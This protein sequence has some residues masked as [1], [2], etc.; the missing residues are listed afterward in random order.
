LFWLRREDGQPPPAPVDTD[1]TQSDEDQSLR[2]VDQ[3]ALMGAVLAAVLAI[4]LPK[5]R[6]DRSGIGVGVAL[7]AI[8]AGYYR[9][10]PK[11]PKE[12]FDAWTRA[13]ALAGVT[14]L[15]L[16][17]ALAYPAQQKSIHKYEYQCEQENLKKYPYLKA[18]RLDELIDNCVGDKAGRRL[19]P[20]W[21]ALAI[22]IFF[23]HLLKWHPKRRPHRRRRRFIAARPRI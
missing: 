10:P 13:A 1:D 16:C 11:K 17:I 23:G 3:A 2:R 15:C 12:W 19:Q 22:G 7:V 8:I 20:A 14:A 21:L 4:F 6:W 18:D 9:V 5:G